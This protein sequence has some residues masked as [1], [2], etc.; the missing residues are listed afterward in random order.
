VKKI[1]LWLCVVLWFSVV[2]A[3]DMHYTQ[4]FNSPLTLN[5]ALTG[6]TRGS[7]R[8]GMAHRSQWFGTA[9]AGFF[10]APFSTPSVFFDAPISINNDAVGLGGIFISDQTG[11]NAFSAFT[12]CISASYIKGLG[13][14]NAHQLA[15]GI[16]VG[17]T[18]KSIRQAGLRF[19]NQFVGT[20]FFSTL[21]SE[22]Q[23]AASAIG[24][25]NLN[26]GVLW[27]GKINRRLSMY[28]GG[29]VFNVSQ[30]RNQFL[31]NA[32]EN[33]Y[34]RWNIHTGIDITLGE[35]VHLLPSVMYMRSKTADQMLPGVSVAYDITPAATISLGSLTRIN[36]GTAKH[37][38]ADATAL[39]GAFDFQGF[40]FGISYDF[41]VLELKKSRSGL[42]ALEVTMIYIGRIKKSKRII[43][44]PMF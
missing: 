12:G 15:A 43:F 41:T 7:Y 36:T 18:H 39:Y 13:K 8:V 4:F 37:I 2:I 27:F 6:L 35:R 29:S 26:G 14:K 30:S 5:P 22:E 31:M 24:T 3:Q 38:Q 42:G 44:C 25:I 11:G 23:M 40:K 32:G 33:W 28:A 19:E 20:N 16:Q 17:Y 21:S 1:L 9:N 10:D 34:L